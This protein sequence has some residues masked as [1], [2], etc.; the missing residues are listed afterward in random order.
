MLQKT[1]GIVLHYFKYTDTS[2]IVQVYTKKYGRQSYIFSGIRS[3][4]AKGKIN[5]LQPMNLLEM[6]VYYKPKST[7]Q[8]LS[9]FRPAYAFQ[10]IQNSIIKQTELLFLAEI[11]YKCLKEEESNTELFDF[12]FH[13]IQYFDTMKIGETDF[14]LLFLIHLTK[15]LGFYPAKNFN[16]ENKYFDLK[17]GVY[18]N[19]QNGDKQRLNGNTSRIIYLLTNTS[20]NELGQLNITSV[21]RTKVLEAIV[22]YYQYHL[23]SVKSIKSLEV[24][25]TVF[26]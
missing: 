20:L 15:Y 12:L 8:R 19:R 2:V 1:K 4:K 14:H 21:E 7:M 26:E 5:Y 17:E 23:L 22:D 25:K 24:L 10:N 13:S 11:L 16:P 18:F 9:E 3:K 6:E